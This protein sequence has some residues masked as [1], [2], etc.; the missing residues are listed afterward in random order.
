MI[1]PPRLSEDGDLALSLVVRAGQNEL[2]PGRAF[3]KT[4]AA[5]AAGGTVL[6]ATQAALATTTA[7]KIGTWTLVKWVGIGVVSGVA[8]M[9]GAEI[10]KRELGAGGEETTA[11]IAPAAPNQR[12]GAAPFPPS[13]TPVIPPDVP[14]EEASPEPTANRARAATPLAP[15]EKPAPLSAPRA[16]SESES[17]IAAEVK[18]IDEA[19]QALG[20]GRTSEAL[21]ALARYRAQTTS[22]TLAPE[23]QYLQMEAEL[24]AGDAASARRSA[25]ALLARYPHGAHAARARWLLGD[26]SAADRGLVREEAP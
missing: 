25:E 2:P 1:D 26:R 21:G 5:V 7:A 10:V 3:E 13:R 15:L 20:T 16:G 12:A 9:G 19:R 23:A 14:A 18:L 4:L 6:G 22:R 17:A 11:L 24:A 8:T